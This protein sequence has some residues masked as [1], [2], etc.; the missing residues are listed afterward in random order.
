LP[1]V[2]LD[3]GAEEDGHAPRAIQPEHDGPD[4]EQA[5]HQIQLREQLRVA[6]GRLS[7]KE[8]SVWV[9]IE[10]EGRSFRELADAWGEP[11]GTLLSRKSRATARLRELLSDYRDPS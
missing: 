2:S 11:I 7:A 9:A 4:P 5:Y 6:I 8:R 10:I 3:H 1:T